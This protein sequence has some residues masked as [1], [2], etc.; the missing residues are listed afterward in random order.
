MSFK[1][2]RYKNMEKKVNQ[3]PEMNIQC[4]VSKLKQRI[5]NQL[6]SQIAFFFSSKL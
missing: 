3:D 4:I 5:T 2:K 6:F 1:N